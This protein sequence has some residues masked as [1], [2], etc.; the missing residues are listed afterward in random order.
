MLRFVLLFVAI[1]MIPTG[2]TKKLEIVPVSG[3]LTLDGQP[4]PDCVV[5]FAL[6]QQPEGLENT[7]SIGRTN[8]EGFFTLKTMERYQRNGCPVGECAVLVL[9]NPDPPLGIAPEEYIDSPEYLAAKPKFP[10]EADNGE[11]RFTIPK[12]GT[13]NVQIKLTSTTLPSTN[14]E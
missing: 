1:L 4:V 5:R 9:Y 10:P 12:K 3:Q 8:Q 2:C 14:H 11:L 13:N 7:P 6:I